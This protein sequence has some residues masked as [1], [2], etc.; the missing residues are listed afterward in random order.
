[1]VLEAPK[2]RSLT[3]FTEVPEWDIGLRRVQR[4]QMSRANTVLKWFK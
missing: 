4:D 2:D 3:V 1:M